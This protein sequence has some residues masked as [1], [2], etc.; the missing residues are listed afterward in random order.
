M[1]KPKFLYHG[2]PQKDIE[3]VHPKRKNFQGEEKEFVFAS[4]DKKA[5]ISY[6][7]SGEYSW[8]AGIYNNEYFVALPISNETFKEKDIGGAVHTFDSKNF[9]TH[10]DRKD[11]EWVSEQ[12]EKPVEKEVF[13]S[14]LDAIEDAGI[15]VYFLDSEENY[16]KYFQMKQADR[17]AAYEF[18]KS[19]SK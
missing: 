15:K 6:L 18:L 8:S 1:E 10:D 11:Y 7:A 14:A 5:A 13:D 12:E 9:R 17:K 19:F 16:Q 3:S 2:T 4:P